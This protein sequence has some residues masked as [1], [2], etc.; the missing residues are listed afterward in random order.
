VEEHL[1]GPW[2]GLSA[3]R[4]GEQGGGQQVRDLD[5]SRFRSAALP[6][7]RVLL[8]D[9]TWTTGSSA[10]SAAM[11]LR[12]AGASSI[13]TVVLGRH[14]AGAAADVGGLGP[15]TMPFSPDRCAVHQDPA[16]GR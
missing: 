12:E 3:P 4:G 5:P 2:A 9:D 1:A 10:Q 7:A 15:A 16:V 13:I 11:A 14:V 8:L 6:G